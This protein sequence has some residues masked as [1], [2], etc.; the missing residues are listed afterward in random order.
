MND[1]FSLTIGLT[2]CVK[3][4]VLMILIC[5]Q[6]ENF[7]MA[8]EEVETVCVLRSMD[9]SCSGDSE[10]CTLKYVFFIGVHTNLNDP[11][12]FSQKMMVACTRVS[13]A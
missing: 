13:Y 10:F 5:L 8:V 6:C 12:L 2:S 1:M 11:L 9:A 7:Y 3:K 4:F